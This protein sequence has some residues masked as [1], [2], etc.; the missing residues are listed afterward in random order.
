MALLS[1][2]QKAQ[3]LDL[4]LETLSRDG[5]ETS[6]VKD[7]LRALIDAYDAQLTS[8]AITIAA[9]VAEPLRT[10]VAGSAEQ[11]AA[12]KAVVVLKETFI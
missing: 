9:G 3:A 10:T 1:A 7:D 2:P 12:F 4:L 5:V 8:L 11:L 6:L